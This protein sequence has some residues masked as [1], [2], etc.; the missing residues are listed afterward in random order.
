LI[1]ST[2]LSNDYTGMYPPRRLFI[3]A[4]LGLFTAFA[5]GIG[6][7][8]GSKPPWPEAAFT[9]HDVDTA[10]QE[11]LG[12]SLNNLAPSDK[13]KLAIPKTAENGAIVPLT[14]YADLDGVVSISLLAAKNPHALTSTYMI[15]KGT[16]PYVS[17]RIKMQKTAVV[18][19]V[20]KANGKLY[21]ASKRVKVAVGGCS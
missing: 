10:L 8:R 5:A 15:P 13:I 17:T 19:A 2:A 7:P 14:V 9:A 1:Y 3:K 12:A 16:L 11:I 6:M 18:I 20:V 4:A 21:S